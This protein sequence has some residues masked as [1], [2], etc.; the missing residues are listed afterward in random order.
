MDLK[1]F[2]GG[3]GAIIGGFLWLYITVRSKKNMP[4]LQTIFTFEG[5]TVT[6]GLFLLGVSLIIHSIH[7]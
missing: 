6:L 2:F 5:I 1:M 7:K 4:M 3:I